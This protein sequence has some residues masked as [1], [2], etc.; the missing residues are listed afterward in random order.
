MKILLTGYKGFIGSQMLESLEN[1]GHEVSTY[2]WGEILPSVVE[3]DWVI[4]VGAISSTTEKDVEKVMRQNVDFTLQLYNA[5]KTHEVNFQF[6]SSASVYG[7]NQE[8]KEDSPVDPRTP[9]A[10]SKYLCERYILNHPGPTVAQIF[11]YF[12]VYG[13]KGEEHKGSQASPF[14]QFTTQARENGVIRV[15]ENSQ[16]YHRDFIHVSKIIDYHDQF[17]ECGP[18]GIFNLGSGKTLSFLAVA[19]KIA[20]QYNARIETT[21]MPENLKCSY[22]ER[23]CADMTKTQKTLNEHQTQC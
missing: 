8:F 7:L 9:Y 18:S 14:C 1:K 12:N 3:Q 15:F 16:N 6:A 23:T 21:V 22:Q 11:R 10:W 4:H 20:S 19:E 13:P 5:C 17:L 2:E